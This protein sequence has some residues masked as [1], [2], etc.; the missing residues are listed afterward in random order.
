MKEELKEQFLEYLTV[1]VNDFDYTDMDCFFE[2]CTDKE[3]EELMDIPLKVV[4][5]K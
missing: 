2:E 1:I 4:E 5:D 3:V